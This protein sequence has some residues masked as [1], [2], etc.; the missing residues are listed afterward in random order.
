MPDAVP[1]NQ[2]LTPVGLPAA[3]NN[4]ATARPISDLRS[5]ERLRHFEGALQQHLKMVG[6][7]QADCLLTTDLIVAVL[8]A[9]G[10]EQDHP[11]TFQPFTFEGHP[12][13]QAK[14]LLQEHPELA[15]QMV[16]EP[17][18]QPAFFARLLQK[19]EPP[20]RG[21]EAEV[22]ARRPGDH[23]NYREAHEQCVQYLSR[24]GDLACELGAK[25]I[26]EAL[27]H[28]RLRNELAWILPG[29]LPLNLVHHDSAAHP[30]SIKLEFQYL[31]DDATGTLGKARYFL[32]R[33]QG[34][35]LIYQPDLN[36]LPALLGLINSCKAESFVIY[37]PLPLMQRILKDLVPATANTRVSIFGDQSDLMKHAEFTSFGAL[38]AFSNLSLNDKKEMAEIAE[39]GSM[40]LNKNSPIYITMNTRSAPGSAAVKVFELPAPLKRHDFK[41]GEST[42]LAHDHPTSGNLKTAHVMVRLKKISDDLVFSA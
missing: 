35:I 11:Q 31:N 27:H 23:E 19:M 10:R 39:L 12:A 5:D 9:F 1:N 4:L 25:L 33:E 20:L 7:A 13:L 8:H 2:P 26:V 3:A 15:K 36:S 21:N 17:A 34:P 38:L 18:S 28:P 41:V 40:L 22:I 32:P 29:F 24:A 30:H 14:K 42:S 37:E 16:I 6:L